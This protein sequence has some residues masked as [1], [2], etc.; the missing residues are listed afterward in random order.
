MR[1][2]KLLEKV[3]EG[4]RGDWK[5]A[6]KNGEVLVDNK[7]MTS[8]NIIVS[9]GWQSIIVKGEHITTPKEYYFV[10]Y[11]PV[12]VVTATK[13]E[14]LP[15]VLSCLSEADRHARLF[16]VGRLDRDTEGLVL[17]TNN[18]P[19]GYKMLNPRHHVDK[20]YYVE[21]N[22]SLTEDA[23]YRLENGIEFL[24][25][26]RCKPAK[27]KV[28]TISESVSSFDLTISEGKYHQVKKMCRCI[29][30]KVTYLKRVRFGPL[31][32]DEHLTPGTYRTLTQD[33]FNLLKQYFE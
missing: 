13:D 31:V 16:P 21:T 9:P 7:R 17:I 32:L 29:G 20:T 28:H 5:K 4:S 3:V 18:G 14:H 12:G 24:D 8:G 2:D 25:G 33:E 1:L 26:T 19:L 22:Q 10:L 15:T 30:H 6:I 11:K 23:I 27:V